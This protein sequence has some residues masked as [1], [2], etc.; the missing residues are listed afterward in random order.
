VLKED[1]S[2]PGAVQVIRWVKGCFDAFDKKYVS[3]V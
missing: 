1:E 3:D 2:C